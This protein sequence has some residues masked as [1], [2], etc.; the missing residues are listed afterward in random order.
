ME[1][2]VQS[3][4]PRAIWQTLLEASHQAL[5][6]ATPL[7]LDFV[8][9]VESMIDASRFYEFSNGKQAIIP[10][11]RSRNGFKAYSM[12]N[13]WG[14]GGLIAHPV[15]NKNEFD[16]IMNDLRHIGVMKVNI[17]PSPLDVNFWEKMG[18]FFDAS[19]EQST[20]ILDISKGFEHFWSATIHSGT[21]NHIRK[22]EKLGLVVE[23]DTT[24]QAVADFYQL[25]L[26]WNENR[27]R[28][29]RF[30]I[31]PY[32][33]LAKQREPLNKFMV[34]S[35]GLGTNC[36]VWTA[37]LNGVP[38]S[39]A[40]LLLYNQH[41]FFWRAHSDKTRIGPT[42]A[43]EVLQKY[44]IEESCRQGCHYYHMGESGGVASLMQYKEKFGAVQH[45]YREY[46]LEQLPLSKL[47]QSIQM[48]VKKIEMSYYSGSKS[49]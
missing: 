47:E 37:K 40:I 13:G 45:C 10:L 35:D 17:R 44:M 12:P 43:N 21:R 34:V 27:A 26:T 31:L 48:L 49:K 25:Y 5:V 11:I 24:G 16:L 22:G 41:A 29:R 2:R 20:H 46:V 14:Q 3:P 15:L 42:H 28:D 23:C 36:Q 9:K 33:W 7:W 6:F 4:A 8:T 19:I 18:D 39:A 38:I 32:R 1:F 30:P